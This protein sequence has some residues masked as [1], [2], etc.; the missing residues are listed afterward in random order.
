MKNIFLIGDSIRCGAQ[1]YSPG[2][3]VYV[4]E[5]L[6]DKCKVFAPGENCRFTTH[7]LR[8]LHDWAWSLCPNEKIDLVHWNNG[9]WDCLRLFGDEPL[10]DLET[11]GKTLK[12]IYERIRILFPS[13]K[14]V[15]ALT[16]AVVEKRFDKK[17]LRFNAD[18]EKYN[19]KAREVLSGLNVEFNDLYS[20]SSKF[21]E[22]YYCDAV[23]FSE[24]G[25]KILAEHVVNKCL[26][27]L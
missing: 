12:R 5:A 8:F 2:Y 27:N 26:E 25:S 15:F 14:I 4:N 6:K 16:T 9:L 11:Y 1:P 3:G 10:V 17:F 19:E 22:S 13:A 20:V 18:V 23:H 24:K 21:D 7:T